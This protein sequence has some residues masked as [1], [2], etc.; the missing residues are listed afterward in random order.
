ME[1]YI[2]NNHGIEDIYTSVYPSNFTLDK[3]FFDLDYGDDILGDAKKLYNWCLENKIQAVPVVSGNGYRIHIYVITRP[4]I[5]GT[6]AKINLTRAT[7]SI[8]KEVYGPFK[9]ISHPNR[10]GKLVRKLRTKERIIAPDPAVCGDLRRLNRLPN[11]LRPPQNLNY[12]T[13]LPPDKFMDMTKSDILSHQ[14]STHHYDYKIDYRKAP[15]LTSFEYD[16][17]D[18]DNGFTMWEPLPETEGAVLGGSN[19]NI[20]LKNILRPCLYRHITYIHPNHVSRTA[21][22]IDLLE[23]GYTP[24]QITDLFSTLGWEDFEYNTTL[25]QVKSCRKYKPYSCRKLRDASIPIA[26]CVH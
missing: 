16:F 19:P 15:L 25:R 8:L 17:E 4:K 7:F 22:A 6:E 21:S 3:I 23:L 24:E 20:F 12:C 1:K 5:Y 18:T 14:K 13:Y 10:E 9:Q 2:L 26:C 11:T